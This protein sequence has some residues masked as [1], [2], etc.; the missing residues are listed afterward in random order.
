M[1][2]HASPQRARCAELFLLCCACA[3]ALAA[4][5]IIFEQSISLRLIALS[6]APV[7]PQAARQ[8]LNNNNLPSQRRYWRGGGGGHGPDDRVA[9]ATRAQRPA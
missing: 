6:E 4:A 1:R 3:P 7:R 8:S 9:E 2:V 5:G